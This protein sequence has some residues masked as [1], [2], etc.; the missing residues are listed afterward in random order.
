METDRTIA[1]F[2]MEIALEVGMSTYS[3]GLGV[4]AGDTIRAAADLKIPM[5][6]VTLLHRQGYFYQRLDE[7]GW[8]HEE[9]AA[10]AVNDFVHEMP[11]RTAVTIEGRTV[12]LRAWHYPVR[13]IGGFTVPVYFLD[14]DVPDNAAWDRTLTDT[15]Y[16]GDAHYR[17]CQEVLLGIG[18]VR[19]RSEERR[20]GKECRSRWSPYH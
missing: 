7:R 18:G 19:M 10:W 12:H 11:A 4:L 3:G 14:A 1:Y 15:L 16:G 2:S 8:Q 13:G 9:P 6:A 5:V 20:V 17:L